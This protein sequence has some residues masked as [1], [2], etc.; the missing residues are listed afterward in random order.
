MAKIAQ[1]A[2]IVIRMAAMVG[3]QEVIHNA[4]YTLGVNYIGTS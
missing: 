2:Q 1:D 4:L 3:V